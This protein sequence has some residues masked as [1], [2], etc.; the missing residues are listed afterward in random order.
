VESAASEQVPPPG[1]APAGP[2]PNQQSYQAAPAAGGM[3]DN[4]AA[5]LCYVLGFITGILFLVLE[6]YNKNREIR[7]HAFQ[8]IFLSVGVFVL[9]MAVSIILPWPLKLTLSPLIGLGSF[10][11]WLFILF[12]TYQGQKVVLPFIGPMAE[13]QA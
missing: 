5:T 10:I 4:V 9:S 2:P 12:K 6:P 7:F 11:L 8:S 1:G 13:K 3:T